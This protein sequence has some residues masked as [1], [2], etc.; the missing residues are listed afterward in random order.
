M[1]RSATSRRS[2]SRA[3]RTSA[4]IC[5]FALSTSRCDS[6]RAASTR[7]FCSSEASLHGLGAD[8]RRLGVRRAEPRRVLLLLP[9]RLGAGRLRLVQRLL[10]RL[11]SLLHLGEERLVEQPLQDDQEDH[12]VDDLDDQRLVEA[13]RARPRGRPRWP[14]TPRPGRRAPARRRGTR[15]TTIPLRSMQTHSAVS[16]ITRCQTKVCE[17]YHSIATGVNRPGRSGRVRDDP[18]P[19][20]TSPS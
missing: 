4:S 18:A 6:A 12:E 16:S 14:P 19:T 3:R 11:R 2:S 1:A 7:R 10:D 5:A 9:R 8:R 13:D 20:T 15:A 17:N